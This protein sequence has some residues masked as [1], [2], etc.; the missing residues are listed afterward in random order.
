MSQALQTPLVV[1]ADEPLS[2]LSLDQLSEIANSAHT[3]IEGAALRCGSIL[4]GAVQHAI[5][6][7][8]ALVEVK[9]RVGHGKFL[10]W[11]RENF[12]GSEDTAG[13]YMKIFKNKDKLLSNSASMRNL[14]VNG[15]LKLLSKGGADANHEETDG[16]EWYTPENF[17]DCVREFLGKIDLDPAS[18]E[19]AQKIVRAKR[20]YTKTDDGLTKP[21]DGNVFVNPPYST[22]LIGKFVAKAIAEQKAKRASVVV[23][24]VNN[25]TDT[26]WFHSLLERSPVCLTDG[27]LEFWRPNQTTFAARQGQAVFCLG[28]DVKKFAKSFSKIGK[29]LTCV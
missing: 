29:T 17:M 3:E 28:G 6:A 2:D 16:D 12:R 24:L 22:P 8:S 26:S 25:C 11:L 20:F 1:A 13:R 19:D 27:R 10:A 15:C 23:L 18:S 14:S 4:D 5:R 21:W 7:G 9:F